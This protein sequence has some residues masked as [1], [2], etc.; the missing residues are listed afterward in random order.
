MSRNVI[1]IAAIIVFAGYLYMKTENQQKQMVETDT[2]EQEMSAQIDASGDS[3]STNSEDKELIE[4][5]YKDGIISRIDSEGDFPK[6]YVTADYYRIPEV[7]KTN[8]MKVLFKNFTSNNSAVTS[9][10]VYDD[11]SGD[12]VGTYDEN[13][14]KDN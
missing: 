1:L 5:L 10:T 2:T 7:D 4:N 12:M 11:K 13:G 6:V 9:F 8:I 14:F 3:S